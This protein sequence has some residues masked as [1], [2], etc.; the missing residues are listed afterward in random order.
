MLKVEGQLSKCGG[1]GG[2]STNVTSLKKIAKHLS[3]ETHQ[4]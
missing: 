3:V 2:K 1:G 4:V